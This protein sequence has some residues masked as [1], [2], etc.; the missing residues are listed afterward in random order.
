[1]AYKYLIPALSLVALSAP[2]AADSNNVIH[3]KYRA[4]ELASPESREALLDRIKLN[5]A[6]NCK[7]GSFFWTARLEKECSEQLEHDLVQAIGDVELV[8]LAA[9][10][11]TMPF[12]AASR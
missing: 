10:K 5:A 6:S 7:S 2:A 4:Q 3:F 12:R 11:D 1:M 9:E 8:A